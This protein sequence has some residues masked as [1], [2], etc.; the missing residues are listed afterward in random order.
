LRSKELIKDRLDD[1]EAKNLLKLK[2]M[3]QRHGRCYG[4]PVKELTEKVP[5]P[6]DKLSST[7]DRSK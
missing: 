4:K 3:R 7:R 1:K 5:Y 2:H 6:S